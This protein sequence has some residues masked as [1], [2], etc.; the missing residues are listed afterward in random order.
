M[1]NRQD[2]N[3][4]ATEELFMDSVVF[5]QMEFLGATPLFVLRPGRYQPNKIFIKSDSQKKVQEYVVNM[6][7]NATIFAKIL[8]T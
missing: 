3:S 5:A 7:G 1:V 2:R 8:E 6:L 4:V